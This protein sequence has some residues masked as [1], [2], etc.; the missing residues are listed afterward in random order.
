VYAFN[1]DPECSAKARLKRSFGDD[2][3]GK[4]EDTRSESILNRLTMLLVKLDRDHPTEGWHGY[5]QADGPRWERNVTR[6]PYHLIVPN[7]I[8]GVAI[9][10]RAFALDPQERPLLAESGR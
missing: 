7:G 10:I 6:D 2:A 4:I 3:T 9:P 5:L 1:P 8:R